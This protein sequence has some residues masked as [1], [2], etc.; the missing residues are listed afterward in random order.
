LLNIA[1]SIFTDACKM[2]LMGAGHIV[3]ALTGQKLS[4]AEAP[5]DSP[6]TAMNAS[7]M[8]ADSQMGALPFY[9]VVEAMYPTYWLKLAAGFLRHLA[10]PPPG[11]EARTVSVLDQAPGMFDSLPGQAPP[12]PRPSP[13]ASTGW[14]PM[15]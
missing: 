11:D 6:S 13:T 10:P 5:E 2:S 14:G 9:S 1:M 15:P 8:S 12:A 3:S 4:T 7:P